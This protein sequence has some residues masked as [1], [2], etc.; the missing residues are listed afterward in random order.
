[1]PASSPL[2]ADQHCIGCLFKNMLLLLGGILAQ[3]LAS[4]IPVVVIW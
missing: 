1:M 3:L 4:L 2:H